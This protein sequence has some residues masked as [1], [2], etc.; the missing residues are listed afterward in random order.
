MKHIMLDL[1]T[2]GTR[3]NAAIVAIG[4]CE[5]D[6]H[7]EGTHPDS[8]YVQVGLE[9]SVQMGL[10]IDTSTILWWMQQSDAARQQTFGGNERWPL[11][12]AVWRFSKFVS[13]RGKDVAIWGNGA[14]FD[15]VIIRSA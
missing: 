7:G 13:A 5:F 12:D 15:N 6:P 9:S 3:P 2:M 8:H 14:T 11:G 1:E 10:K 4:A